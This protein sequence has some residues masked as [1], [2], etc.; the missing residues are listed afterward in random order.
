MRVIVVGPSVA[1]AECKD[2]FILLDVV[3]FQSEVRS[4]AFLLMGE[5]ESARIDV[6]LQ[7]DCVQEIASWFARLRSQ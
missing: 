4:Q 3:V 5:S 7:G 2:A 1:V 6:E